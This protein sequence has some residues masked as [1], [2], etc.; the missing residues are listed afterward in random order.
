MRPSL[1]H[2]PARRLS[3]SSDSRTRACRL[4]QRRPGASTGGFEH[5]PEP[6]MPK[7]QSPESPEQRKALNESEKKASERQPGSY[8]ERETDDKVVEIGPIDENDS[9]IKGI[10]PK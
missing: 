10:D 7:P 9:A 1:K 6:T 8:K 3:E 5:R 2:D 4:V